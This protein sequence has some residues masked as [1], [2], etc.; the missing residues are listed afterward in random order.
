[1]KLRHISYEAIAA[2]VPG[3]R[4]SVGYTAKVLDLSRVTI[5]RMIRRGRLAGAEPDASGSWRIMADPRCCDPCG[6]AICTV[7]A[8]ENRNADWAKQTSG[9]CDEPHPQGCESPLAHRWRLVTPGAWMHR[10]GSEWEA[11]RNPTTHTCRA[12][13]GFR[14]RS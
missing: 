6:R 13:S 5:H 2:V 11:H 12:A 3:D 7:A 1:M 4:Y 10:R 8:A 14:T 9:R